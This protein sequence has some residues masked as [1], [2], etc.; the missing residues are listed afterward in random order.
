MTISRVLLA[1]AALLSTL[2]PLP[3]AVFEHA[4]GPLP[5][6]QLQTA[7][8]RLWIDDAQTGPCAGVLVLIPGRHGDGRPLAEKAEWQQLARE[9]KLAL[10][11]C[12]FAD[13]E[14][15][16]YQ[17]DLG[18]SVSKSINQAL[19]QLATQARRP[20]LARAPLAFWGTS[21]GS[22]VS[23][24]YAKAFPDSVLA[25][26]S[27][28]G[29]SGPRGTT[30]DNVDIPM[31]FALGSNDKPEWVKGSID[32]IRQ[33]R[34]EKAPW[35][36]AVHPSEGHEVGRSLE[37][38]IPFLRAVIPQRLAGAMPKPDSSVRLKK[39]ASNDGWLAD[40]ETREFAASSQFKGKKKEAIWLPDET[41][42][43]AWAAYLK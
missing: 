11:G 5:E 10:L 1:T 32:S 18:Q 16:P 3:A 20:E 9:L 19:E 13:G 21:A 7:A 28:K 39:L 40:P 22:N 37:L 23:V 25:I 27:S 8:Y 34:E 35:T 26:A 15:F 12:Q 6:V 17:D 2:L 29:T 36:L 14:P 43:R 41:T 42:A 24:N 33:G 4:A 31:C 38:A 30:K